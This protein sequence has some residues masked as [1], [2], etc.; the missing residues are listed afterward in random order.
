MSMSHLVIGDRVYRADYIDPDGIGTIVSFSRTPG[1]VIVLW[2][3]G[4][5][6]P[7]CK[8]TDRID[9]LTLAP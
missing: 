8:S 6:G 4:S 5:M 1:Y 3:A 2:P 7:G 9:S